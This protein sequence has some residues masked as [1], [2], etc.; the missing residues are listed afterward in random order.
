MPTVAE[1]LSSRLPTVRLRTVWDVGVSDAHLY[2]ILG[3]EGT[4]ISLHGKV[5][6][7]GIPPEWAA[8]EE[9]VSSPFLAAAV[10][11]SKEVW[12]R[13][14]YVRGRKSSRKTV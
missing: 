14:I 7:G 5:E 6:A 10:A 2:P 1:G 3:K 13:D 12:V 8:P 4:G 11:F 9:Q